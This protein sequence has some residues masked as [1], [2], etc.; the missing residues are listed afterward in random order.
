V[1][2]KLV[3]AVAAIAL[4]FLASIAAVAIA[5]R[6]TDGVSRVAPPAASDPA[7]VAPEPGPVQAPVALPVAEPVGGAER[8]PPVPVGWAEARA[9]QL[10]G[11]AVAR[12]LAPPLAPCFERAAAPAQ[13]P[14]LTLLVEGI[15]GGLRIVDAV[16]A[17]AVAPGAE[18]LV[19]CA[20]EILRDR[21]VSAGSF[22]PGDRYQATYPLRDSRERTSPAA[23]RPSASGPGS[24]PAA[25]Y[26]RQRGKGTGGA[27][28]PR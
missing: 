26:R 2:N 13:A 10:P 14:V 23:A 17:T 24:A 16:P 1:R 11:D 6:S 19:E 5:T 22:A 4:F 7:P 21:K 28:A 3:L 25:P 9:L 18:A 27:A 12:E 15:P 20:Q 8:G